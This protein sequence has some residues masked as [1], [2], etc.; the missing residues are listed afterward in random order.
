MTRPSLQRPTLL[1]GLPRIWR[2]VHTLQLGLDPAYAVLV[3]LPDPVLAHLL[4]LLDGT[5]PERTLLHLAADLGIPPAEAGTLLEV[6]AEAGLVVPAQRLIPPTF[7]TASRR[8]LSG[9]AA[10]LALRP[11]RLSRRPPSRGQT[12][13]PASLLRKRR[14]AK[15]VVAGRSRLAAGIAVALAQAGIGHIHADLAGTIT[16]EDRITAPLPPSAVGTPRATAVTEA[17]EA[18]APATDTRPIRSAAPALTIQFAPDKPVALLALSHLQR[19]RPYLPVT[20]REAT[21]VIGPLVPAT[22]RPCL[23]CLV[24]YRNE[25]TSE[26]L[27]LLPPT[28]APDQLSSDFPELI[29]PDPVPLDFPDPITPD[30]VPLDFPDPLPPDCPDPISAALAGPPPTTPARAV[31]EP[32]APPSPEP[33]DP[34]TAARAH[35]SSDATT[36]GPD[37]PDASGSPSSAWAASEGD[38]T[39]PAAWPDGH[40]A[41]DDPYAVPNQRPGQEPLSVAGAWAA[42]GYVVAE[43]LLFIDGGEPESLGAEVEIWSPSRIRRRT[44][45]PHPNCA[46]A[47]SRR[48]P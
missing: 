6:L 34:P 10:A 2:G 41:M 30:P 35:A 24:L 20:V 40:T 17:V 13:S 12:A 22:G 9:E 23:N 14:E 43:A 31:P 29:S 28:A 18:A 7:D 44:W 42:I 19:R 36:L 46:C 33:V 37:F 32:P 15:V 3:D 47:S 26:A 38:F 4:D 8:L 5:R 27:R 25:T 45:T 16:D 39:L 21:T 48:R 11:P 1:P